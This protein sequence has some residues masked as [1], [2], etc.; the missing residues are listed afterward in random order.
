M[1]RKDSYLDIA[2]LQEIH[3]FQ[4][5]KQSKVVFLSLGFDWGGG[6]DSICAGTYFL[7]ADPKYP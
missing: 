6:G 2:I 4:R 3:R 1:I 5:Q 7:S